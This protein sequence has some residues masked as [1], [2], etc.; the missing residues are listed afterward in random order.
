MRD[1]TLHATFDKDVKAAYI[2][3]SKGKIAK[4]RRYGDN[5][6]IDYDENGAVLGIEI[7]NCEIDE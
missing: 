3:V 6:H 7:L 1:L 4:T 5:L 2:Y